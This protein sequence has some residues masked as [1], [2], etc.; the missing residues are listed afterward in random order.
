M[1]ALHREAQMS[2]MHDYLLWMLA[3]GILIF[4]EL[5]TGTFYL[6]VLGLAALAGGV[7][8]WLGL[9]FWAQL[10]ATLLIAVIGVIMIKRRRPSRA[11]AAGGGNAIDIGQL[12]TLDSWVSEADGI[13]RVHY[14][15]ALWDAQVVGE[16]AAGST[17]FIRSV[18]GS[19][20][21]VGASRH[22]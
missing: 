10:L 19:T 17:Y 7:A 4:V 14:R 5:V 13:A 12:V 18:E 15:G 9:P 1:A 11:S 8:G 21:R 6:L 22:D 20:L 2:G 16:R 3:G